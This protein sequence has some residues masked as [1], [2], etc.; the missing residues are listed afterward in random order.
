[1]RRPLAALNPFR[2]KIASEP[3]CPD[4]RGDLERH[5]PDPSRPDR[6]L[7]VCEECAS[8]FLIDPHRCLIYPIPNVWKGSSGL[9]N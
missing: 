2:F 8:W 1:M 3:L 7:G 6:L 9:D 4:C 5:Q